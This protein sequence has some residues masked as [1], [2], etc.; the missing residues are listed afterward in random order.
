MRLIVCGG[1]DFYDKELLF[2]SLDDLMHAQERIRDPIKY[3]IHGNARGADALAHGWAV[4]RY[5][6]PIMVPALWNLFGAKAGA[7]RNENMLGLGPDLVVAFP[8]GRGTAHMMKIAT[9]ANIQTLQIAR[10]KR[11][12]ADT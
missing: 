8:G 9:A 7:I 10:P 11:E 6:Q 2:S 3:L 1:R 12:G 4:V 5:I